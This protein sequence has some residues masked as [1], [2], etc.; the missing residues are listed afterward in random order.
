[1]ARDDKCKIAD[2]DGFLTNS[3]QNVKRTLAKAFIEQQSSIFN[4]RRR[5]QIGRGKTND[6]LTNSNR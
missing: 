5:R 3:I 1:M 6:F 2:I 4:N